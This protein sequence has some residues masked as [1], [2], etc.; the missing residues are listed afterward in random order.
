MLRDAQQQLSG[1]S[2]GGY[3]GYG[4]S[5]PDDEEPGAARSGFCC[6]IHCKP[7]NKQRS[8]DDR[9]AFELSPHFLQTCLRLV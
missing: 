9:C 4:P 7:I 3:G 1:A 8:C 5:V 6:L 2:T